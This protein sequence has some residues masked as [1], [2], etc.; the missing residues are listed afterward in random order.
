MAD[1]A[2]DFEQ[3]LTEL[4]R[5]VRQLEAGELTLERALQLYEEGVALARTCQERLETAEQR[6]A[7][8]VRGAGEPEELP[9]AGASASDDGS[10]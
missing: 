1:E 2:P 3:T 8:L 7:R 6:V 9:L 10:R 5:R 4:E